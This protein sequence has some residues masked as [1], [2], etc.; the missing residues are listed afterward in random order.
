MSEPEC[1]TER[2]CPPLFLYSVQGGNS[3]AGACG[4]LPEGQTAL[5]TQST[6][7]MPNLARAALESIFVDL[8]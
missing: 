8:L 5:H 4:D 6:Q 3:Q 2:D 7:A 1:G